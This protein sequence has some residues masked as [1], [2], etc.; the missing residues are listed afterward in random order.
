[1]PL[2]LSMI[3]QKAWASGPIPIRESFHPAE[4]INAY[5]AEHYDV[6][7]WLN[8]ALQLLPD[9]F[10]RLICVDNLIGFRQTHWLVAFEESANSL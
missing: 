9:S 8:M 6:I 7:M 10:W 1:M 2:Y 3:S 4:S 5:Q